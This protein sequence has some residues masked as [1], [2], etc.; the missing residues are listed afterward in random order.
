MARDIYL[1]KIAARREDIA[2]TLSMGVT[3]NHAVSMSIPAL[4]GL[5]WMRYGHDKVFFAAAGLALVMLFFTSRIRVP[6][7]PGQ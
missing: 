2:P 4:G 6:G 7:K 1:S 5:V 3:I